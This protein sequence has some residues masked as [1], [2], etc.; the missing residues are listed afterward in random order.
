MVCG[1][2]GGGCGIVHVVHVYVHT[3]CS[4]SFLESGIDDRRCT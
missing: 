4:R 3:A 2:V 1:V